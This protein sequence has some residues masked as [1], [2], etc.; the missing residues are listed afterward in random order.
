[1]ELAEADVQ[2]QREVHAEFGSASSELELER[3]LLVAQLAKLHLERARSVDLAKSVIL[4][5]QW[6]IE[7]LRNEVIELRA[8]R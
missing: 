7:D 4:Y 5:L 2:R 1:M 6:E 8:R 3:C